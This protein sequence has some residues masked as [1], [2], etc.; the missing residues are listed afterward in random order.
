MAPSDGAGS[1]ERSSLSRN[2]TARLTVDVSHRHSYYLSGTVSRSDGYPTTS[3]RTAFGGGWNYALTND[4]TATVGAERTQ[5]QDGTTPA[6][7]Y[8]A[9]SLTGN[10]SW[11]F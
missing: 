10:L 2:G 5:Y 7:N 6:L 4:L 11:R 1:V 8:R 9:T 3:L